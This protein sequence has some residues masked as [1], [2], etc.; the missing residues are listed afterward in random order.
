MSHV[1]ARIDDA[2]ARGGVCAQLC[3]LWV[4]ATLAH[5]DLLAARACSVQQ[6]TETEA[7]AACMAQLRYADTRDALSAEDDAWVKQNMLD[8]CDVWMEI[9]LQIDVHT[10]HA[11]HT[12]SLAF[13][14]A[15]PRLAGPDATAAWDELHKT[16]SAACV[17]AQ[18]NMGTAYHGGV[19]ARAS[20]DMAAAARGIAMPA[21]RDAFA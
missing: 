13:D 18:N 21:V 4:R 17:Q 2:R 14:R 19:L 9:V 15:A 20:W 5:N 7:L 6:R 8:L 16:C 10:N 11:L 1:L 3:A 12:V